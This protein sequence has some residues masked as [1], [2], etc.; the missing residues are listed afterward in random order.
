MLRGDP[1]ER[2]IRDQ[3]D[4]GTAGG[5]RGDDARAAAATPG[6]AEGAAGRGKIHEHIAFL[7]NRRL[8]PQRAIKH[9]YDAR[10]L[11]PLT[12]YPLPGAKPHDPARTQQ[13]R[14]QGRR[15]M[16]EPKAPLREDVDVHRMNVTKVTFQGDT[17]R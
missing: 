1:L 15:E 11:V 2:A 16:R 4:S 3:Q 13:R 10:F 6:L 17:L 12:I 9:Q 5:A 7:A 14:A 8:D